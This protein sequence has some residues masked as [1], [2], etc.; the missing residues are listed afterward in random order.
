MWKP[1]RSVLFLVFSSKYAAEHQLCMKAESHFGTCSRQTMTEQGLIQMSGVL[2]RTNVSRS[3]R[4]SAREEQRTAGDDAQFLIRSTFGPTRKSLSELRGTSRESWV[5]HQMGMPV[6]S[7]RAY[8]RE[9]VN[10]RYSFS[11]VSTSAGVHRTPCQ[12]GSRWIQFSFTKDDIG[13]NFELK[14][15]SSIY[16]EGL[17]RTDLDTGFFKSTWGNIANITGKICEVT[18]ELKAEVILSAGHCY[19]K[20][21]WVENVPLKVTEVAAVV[22]S[23]QFTS[24]K[25]G[26]LVVSHDLEPC[27]VMETAVIKVNGSFYR[28]EERL[29]LVQNTPDSPSFEPKL[30]VSRNVVNE[31]NCQAMI[32]SNDTR[33]VPGWLERVYFGGWGVY[34][35]EYENPPDIERLV[36]QPS[37][38][39]DR[40]TQFSCRWTGGI[41]I[42]EAG[43]YI[44]KTFSDDG[45]KLYVDNERV[46][47][48]GGFHGTRHVQGQKEL[49]VGRHELIVDFF[50]AGGG[51]SLGTHYMGPDTSGVW[52]A[53][54]ETLV[55]V[56]SSSSL[57]SCV[58]A[59]G[60]EG[61]FSN[62]MKSVHQFTFVGDSSSTST[63]EVDTRV[64]T[65]P[66]RLSKT[67][68]WTMKA[69]EAED[70]L[71]QRVAWALFQMFGVSSSG[72][73]DDTW[74]EMWLNYYDVFVRGAFG[75]FKDML[76]E[77]I[78]NPVVGKYRQHVGSSSYAF[79][80]TYPS[81][82]L[83]QHL[84]E[85]FTVGSFSSNDVSVV[86]RVLTGFSTSS[87][88]S[89]RGE[90]HDVNMIDPMHIVAEKH[91]TSP[92]PDFQGHFLGDGLPLCDDLEGYGFL[93][94][95]AKFQFVGLSAPHEG[96]LTLSRES[97][98]GDV[99]C[100]G[101]Q[102]SCQPSFIK[103]LSD[104]LA[105]TSDE[106]NFGSVE[107]V[108][109]QGLYFYFLRPVCVD[110]FFAEGDSVVV[111]EVGEVQVSD[112]VVLQV[113][114]TNG[115]LPV[116][117]SYTATVTA[118]AVFDTVPSVS[119]MQAQLTIITQAPD[120]DCS[121]CDGEVKA[122]SQDG[123]FTTFEVGGVFYR[124]LKNLVALEGSTSTFRNP[125]VFVK[126]H[127][128]DFQKG[129]AMEAEVDAL[130][131]GLVSHDR[132]PQFFVRRLI[133]RI[134][135]ADP[136]STYVS[137]VAEAFRSGAY[138]GTTYSG[139][140]GDLAATVAAIILHP[141]AS[142]HG[143]LREPLMKII[144]VMRS[145]GYEDDFRGP[146]IFEDQQN[147]IGQFP[148]HA[149]TA[150]GYSDPDLEVPSQENTLVA[151]QFMNPRFFIGFLN[152]MTFLIR[153]GVSRQ[154]DA[155]TALGISVKF[156]DTWKTRKEVCPQGRLTFEGSANATETLDELDLLL[157]GG[158]LTN[159]TKN[160][161]RAVHV[162]TPGH[163][164]GLKAAQQAIV[165]TA[166]FNTLG[167]VGM[168]EHQNGSAATLLEQLQTKT[169]TA[170]LHTYKALIL[171]F[172]EGGADTFNMIVPQDCPLYDEYV[173]VRQDL[174]MSSA[175]LLAVHTTGQPCV[176]FGVHSSLNFLKSLY[177]LGEGAFVANVGSLVQPT[178]KESLL[179]GIGQSCV[180]LFSHIEQTNAVQT[181]QCQYPGNATKGAGGRLADALA[182]GT[183]SLNTAAFSMSG[184]ERWPE[185]DV[186]V[187]VAV[188]EDHKQL[189]FYE[190]WR[191]VINDLT[192]FAHNNKFAD[193]YSKAFLAAVQSTESVERILNG[194]TTSTDYK[195]DDSLEKQFFD[196]AR[197]I[198][199]RMQRGV[200]RDLFFVRIGGFDHHGNARAGLQALFNDVDTGIE[201]FVTEMR[202]QNMWENIVVLSA[203]EFGRSLTSSGDG[204]DH[205]WAGNHFIVGGSVKGGNILNNYPSSLVDSDRDL[206]RGRLIPEHPWESVMVP[207]AEWMG[208][209]SSQREVV[210]P[211]VN[212]F[213]QDDLI[214]YASLFD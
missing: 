29:G 135:V 119:E 2:S 151:S 194:V 59:C 121:V 43:T 8:Y 23:L 166:E 207:V 44:F 197:L 99:L 106:C 107:I 32:V 188:D 123:E 42:R 177:D 200:E 89:A 126:S 172:M 31:K 94:V 128:S 53:L 170:D 3:N 41:M 39:T 173:R 37:P 144:H 71:R 130:L 213:A 183:N 6:E 129:R 179:D 148:Y 26:V 10:P 155:E 182:S 186:T 65:M 141:E 114:W 9:R 184:L 199:T 57:A 20:K 204:S 81:E 174:A 171:L 190:S 18:E 80:S 30:C 154:C 76:R 193:A 33:Y 178:S 64:E 137:D 117:A 205:G 105:C 97:A 109:V 47:D 111:N 206:G 133:Q 145:M 167:D 138:N 192:S 103:K 34:G 149:P 104:T 49:T 160:L 214:P 120:V 125:P 15:H 84:L 210:F 187:Q 87:V 5:H 131:D 124:N 82:N 211:N 116:A 93:E 85:F 150:F 134:S 152:V 136:S 79:D 189:D 158:R 13:K 46:V 98:L 175:D 195:T 52:T 4:S 100:G 102:T 22:T 212:F 176:S 17:F 163:V 35:G 118:T 161:V 38:P 90:Y 202:E 62:D 7:H 56:L 36:S 169:L 78:Y 83:A 1:L 191:L 91:D 12:K 140:P 164:S 95:G 115:S 198:S 50:Q 86:A 181:L 24:V 147:T 110:L 74:S 92:K 139:S 19:Y 96:V 58:V 55:S 27:D 113:S 196:V 70:Q 45:S 21:W 203:S 72:S 112:D 14:G 88:Q 67:T 142:C 157:T 77:L 201:G 63:Q 28:Y 61:E 143:A 153:S 132:T 68:V 208:M 209:E 108:E 40:E 168:L 146:I 66:A 11:G 122:Y 101:S 127:M 75:S 180:G 51:M 73:L 25:H 185:G 156:R 159:S 162:D 48:N 60:S 54:D 69:L 16:V 165:M